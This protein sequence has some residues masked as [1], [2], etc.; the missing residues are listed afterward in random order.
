VRIKHEPRGI[1]TGNSS[2]YYQYKELASVVYAQRYSQRVA[3][4]LA[5]I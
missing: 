4:R 5:T 1:V 2:Y 3:V